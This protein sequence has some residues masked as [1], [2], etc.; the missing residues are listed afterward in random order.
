LHPIVPLLTIVVVTAVIAITLARRSRDRRKTVGD[1][2]AYARLLLFELGLRHAQALEEARRRGS[3][4]TDLST[5]IMRARLRFQA[6][7][8]SER[9]GTSFDEAVVEILARGDRSLLGAAGA[10]ARSRDASREAGRGEP[11]TSGRASGAR[12]FRSASRAGDGER[13]G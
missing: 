11:A 7:V 4:L 12:G 2:G 8:S 5:E 9:R 13:D 3:I 1:P 6:R 10:T